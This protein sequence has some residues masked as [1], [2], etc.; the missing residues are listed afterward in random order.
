MGVGD[1]IDGHA[2]GKRDAKVEALLIP[3]LTSI[4]R[5]PSQNFVTVLLEGIYNQS[6]GEQYNLPAA[7][8]QEFYDIW[9]NTDPNSLTESLLCMG[10]KADGYI[11]GIKEGVRASCTNPCTGEVQ[12][13]R[14]RDFSLPLTGLGGAPVV[15]LERRVIEDWY[16]ASI[17]GNGNDADPS[18]GKLLSAS[19]P[20]L[21]IHA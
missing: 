18:W 8:F 15:G 16:D 4:F 17:A 19:C 5:N 6:F 20:E 2:L 12:N 13:N 14:R 7:D 11:S 1:T 21:L 3:I 9:P 10:K